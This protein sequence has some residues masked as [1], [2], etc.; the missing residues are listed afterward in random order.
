MNYHTKLVIRG[1]FK[2]YGH[3]MSPIA[4]IEYN[5]RTKAEHEKEGMDYFTEGEQLGHSCFLRDGDKFFHTN[6]RPW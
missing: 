1:D 4:P 3:W 5:Y 2:M 6:I